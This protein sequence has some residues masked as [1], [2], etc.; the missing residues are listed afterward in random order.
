MSDKT[1]TLTMNQ[2]IFKKLHLGTVAYSDETF[3]EVVSAVAGEYR[4]GKRVSNSKSRNKVGWRYNVFSILNL[5]G[6]RWDKYRGV[7]F[8]FS[9]IF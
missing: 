3:D 4:E 6:I 8:Q 2:M 1:G 9:R 5:H 7:I